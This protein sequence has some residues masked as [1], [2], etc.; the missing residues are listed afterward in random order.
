[1]KKLKVAVVGSGV[2][3]AHIEAYQALPDMYDVAVLCDIDPARGQELAR[4]SASRSLFRASTSCSRPAS[5]S[6]TSA[7]RPACIL[8]RPAPR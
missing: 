1:M 3:S 7:R 5:I 2:G 4:Q 6:S 8:S